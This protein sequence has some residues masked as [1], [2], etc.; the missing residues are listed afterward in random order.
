M[1]N[2]TKTG[3][4]YNELSTSAKETV[5]QWYLNDESRCDILSEDFEESFLKYFFSESDLKIQWSLSSC[6]GDGVNIYGELDLNAIL[7]YIK[8]YNPA[9][10]S[11]KYAHD[12][13]NT[14]TE[15]ELKR[16]E[17]YI[18][19]LYYI[20]KETIIPSNGHYCYCMARDIDFAEDITNDLKDQK[21]KN[22]DEKLVNRFQDEVIEIIQGL[23]GEM[24]KYGYDYLY[25]CEDEEIEETCE[26]NDWYFD[27]DGNLC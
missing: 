11:Y 8:D 17:W 5:K 16:L 18:D 4:E 10:H 6:Q 3:Y 23:C 15:K 2:I 27:E 26:A 9:E 1:R 19:N 21:F 20:G 14:F 22:I 24:E 12:P 25:N 13:R 7:L